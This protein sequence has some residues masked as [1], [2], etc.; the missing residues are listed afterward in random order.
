MRRGGQ[1]KAGKKK[2]VLFPKLV[3]LYDEALHG[4]GCELEDVFEE[5]ILCSSKC[6]YP[7][8]LSMT[9][10]G[11]VPS[12]YK[13]YGKAVSPMGCVHKD[14]VVTYKVDGALYVESFERF[15]NRIAET[16]ETRPQPCDDGTGKYLY[17]DVSSR[18]V[19]IY[20]TKEGFVRVK[21]LIRN[22]SDSWN[23]VK[24]TGGR[25]VLCTTDH[26]FE[27]IGKGE[28]HASDLEKGDPML[29]N[30]AS[31]S[32]ET[33]IVPDDYAWLLGFLL[34][35]GCYQNYA[36]FGSIAATGE[37]EIEAKFSEAMKKHFGLETKTVLQE[38]GEKGTYKDIRAVGDGSGSLSCAIEKLAELFG[39]Y[40]KKDRR[41]PVEVFRWNYS[42][43]MAFL[44]G[45]IDADGHAI[46]ADNKKH[47]RNTVELGS[48]NKELALEQM[49][50]AQC[51]GMPARVYQN[52]YNSK[53][54]SKIRFKVDF[55]AVPELASYI[56]CEKKA[57]RI[58]SELEAPQYAT[59]AA[60]ESVEMEE[61]EGFSYDVETESSHFEVSGIYSHNCR[62]FLSPWYER[63]GMY[64]EDESDTPVFVGRFNIG[65]VS[66]NLPMILAKSR[67]D[68]TD[69]YEELDYYLE[70]IRGIHKR[71]YDYLGHMKAS[72]NPLGFCEGGFYGGHLSLEDK[73]EPILDSATASFGFTA[74]N[75]LQEL[76]NGR[77]LV[78]DGQFA[79][80]VMD[81]INRKVEEFK[82]ADH[83]LYAIYGT[84]AESLCTT[85]VTQ[86]R[87]EFGIIKNVSDRP[88]VSNSFHCHVS[89]H[90][91]PIEKQDLEGRFWDKTNGGKI[92]Y[93]R[94][95]VDYNLEAIR[96]L[97]RRAM[98]KG[99]YEGVNMALSYCNECG[100]EELE[101]DVCPECGTM[102]LTK[103]DRMNGYLSYSR[104]GWTS[105]DAASKGT[106]TSEELRNYFSR[107]NAGKMAEIADRVSM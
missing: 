17:M 38:R 13:K 64:P 62:A 82:V 91:T 74:L 69:F 41:I 59:T 2:P 43:K 47:R 39:G 85:Q 35:D 51:L 58:L 99:F 11:Y 75:E 40:Q 84:P 104:T 26:P 86:F 30:S 76:Y 23:T 25:T 102:N 37:D 83:R 3:F 44:A 107:L 61:Y 27:V 50:L 52:H 67:R 93:V 33:E 101:M 65:V 8:W 7:D 60:V 5:G 49:Y 28:V 9:G 4:K 72:M 105:Q 79:L 63:G 29:I 96:V 21:K 42:A 45:M 87:K 18:D 16:C 15:W 94:Y 71:T 48:T 80:E 92:Q 20:D 34:C 98:A 57:S 31:Y 24:L 106:Q 56:C 6:M 66:L 95:P 12:M 88:Y 1:G 32:E 22:Y 100:H 70:M 77:S 54:A 10:E 14:E 73:I 81:H 90:I 19:L 89:E 78:E 103:I 53:D 97:V 36:L 46:S 55:C 68:G